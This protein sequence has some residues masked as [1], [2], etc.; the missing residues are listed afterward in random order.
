MKELN[1]QIKELWDMTCPECYTEQV[2]PFNRDN[3]M[4]PMQVECIFCGEKFILT[5]NRD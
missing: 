1:V 4:Q 3:P 5:Y 2:A